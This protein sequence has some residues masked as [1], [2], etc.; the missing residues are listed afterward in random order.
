MLAV[1]HIHG[2]FNVAVAFL[3]PQVD[4]QRYSQNHITQNISN[5]GQQ[6]MGC[7][8]VGCLVVD[9][10]GVGAVE[11]VIRPHDICQ[12]C[13]SLAPHSLGCVT[14]L[15]QVPSIACRNVKDRGGN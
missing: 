13:V 1:A 6:H 3:V 5:Q 8:V 11:F 10:S 9:R 12:V 2:G 14:L 15:E 7:F 4:L